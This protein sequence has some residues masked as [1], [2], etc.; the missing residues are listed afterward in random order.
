MLL[1][2]YQ[3]RHV[4]DNYSTTAIV[5]LLLPFCV[6]RISNKYLKIS[7]SWARDAIKWKTENTILLEQ[8]QI[9]I[10]KL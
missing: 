2:R 8:F 10:E 6:K 7:N 9:S 3:K 5:Q 1:Y 4:W